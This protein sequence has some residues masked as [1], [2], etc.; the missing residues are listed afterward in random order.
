[1]AVII[2]RP[3]LVYGPNVKAN[4][5]NLLKSSIAEHRSR[6]QVRKTKEI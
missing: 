6:L 2:L 3:P 4:F 1:M 5:L